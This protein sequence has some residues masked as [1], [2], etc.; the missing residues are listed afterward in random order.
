MPIDD[1]NMISEEDLEVA[2]SFDHLPQ[3]Y[4]KYLHE[5]REKEPEAYSYLTSNINS[6]I[7]HI[8]DNNEGLFND[9]PIL[10][11][12]LFA[13]ISLATFKG[14][15]LGERRWKPKFEPVITGE[16]VPTLK[17]LE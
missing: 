16:Y 8:A 14:M 17:D 4:Q 6:M 12:H 15:V 5:I 7:E 9:Y 13:I 1:H 11:Q 2:M 3:E 10:V